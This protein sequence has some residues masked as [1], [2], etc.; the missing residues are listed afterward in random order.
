[1]R[2]RLL[3]GQSQGGVFPRGEKGWGRLGPGWAIGHFYTL[4][5]RDCMCPLDSIRYTLTGNGGGRQGP[6][7][8]SLMRPELLPVSRGQCE[9]ML[10]SLPAQQLTCVLGVFVPAQLVTASRWHCVHIPHPT[11]AENT[12]LAGGPRPGECGRGQL[13]STAQISPCMPSIRQ[14]YVGT[15]SVDRQV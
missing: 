3:L 15:G 12:A 10:H 11:A 13:S 6:S 4:L 7:P 9:G 2:T 5:P 14:W 1:M 8:H